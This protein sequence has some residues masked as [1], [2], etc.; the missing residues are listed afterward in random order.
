[1][2]TTIVAETKL[3]DEVLINSMNFFFLPN[4]QSKVLAPRTWIEDNWCQFQKFVQVESGITL[5][6]Y[7]E[8]HNSI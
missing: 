5:H 6:N 3:L 7:Y 2:V 1:M 8:F 4:L